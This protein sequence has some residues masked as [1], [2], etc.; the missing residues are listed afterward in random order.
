MKLYAHRFETP[1][2]EM[3]SVVDERGRLVNLNFWRA[4]RQEEVPNQWNL[5]GRSLIWD[6][7]ANARVTA[8][9][10][11]YFEGGLFQFDLPLAPGGTAFQRLVWDALCA[12][13][14]GTTISYG[15]LASRLGKPKAARGVGAANAANPIAL[16]VPCHRVIGSNGSLT[17]YA[18]GL[19]LKRALLDHERRTRETLAALE[20]VRAG[21]K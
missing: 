11:A 5:R 14:L 8:A 3:L 13:P 6:A 16:V 10:T 7:A 21:G 1:L 20:T 19:D 18:A 2:A 9:V 17:G 12:I 15:E 4:S